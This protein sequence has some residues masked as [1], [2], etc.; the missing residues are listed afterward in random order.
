MKND[1]ESRLT[2]IKIQA[3]NQNDTPDNLIQAINRTCEPMFKVDQFYSKFGIITKRDAQDLLKNNIIAA[4]RQHDLF[5][6][7]YFREQ[8]YK[9][10][11]TINDYFMEKIH[12]CH[13]AP[14]VTPVTYQDVI[15]IIDKIY[16]ILK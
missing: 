16:K 2:K 5:D 12:G 6:A 1:L 14:T 11:N 4:K 9:L 15:M 13:I 10:N 3:I 8:K 7:E